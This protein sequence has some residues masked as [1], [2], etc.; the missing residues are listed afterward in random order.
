MRR[1]TMILL[2]NIRLINW[3]GFGNVTMPIGFFTLI[4]GKNGN[5]KSV[6]LDAI[7]YA[8][9]GDTVFNKS[10]DSH[11]TRTLLSYTRGL[12]DATAKTY[13]RPVEKHPNVITHIALEYYDDVETKNFILGTII[14]TNTSDNY[15]SYRYVIDNDALQNIDHLYEEQNVKKPYT[16]SAFQ[17]KY[18][19]KLMNKEQGIAKFMQ[20]TGLKLDSE[21]TRIYLRKLR[22]I[23]SYDPNAKMDQFI[24]DSVLENKKIDFSK[25]IEAREYINKSKS[26]LDMIQNEIDEIDSILADYQG[27][28]GERKRLLVDDI[29][30]VYKQQIDLKQEKESIE[31]KATKA[32]L[33]QTMALKQKVEIEE[34]IDSYQKSLISIEASL[35]NL[36]CVK[37]IQEVKQRLRKL[38]EKQDKL[39][40]EKENLKFFQD[41]IQAIQKL[42]S[43]E[44]IDL[45]EQNILSELCTKTYSV[46]DKKLAVDRLKEAIDEGNKKATEKLVECSNKNQNIEEKISIQKQI[47]NDCEKNHVSFHGIPDYCN[48][49]EEI[50]REFQLRNLNTAAK[51]ACEYVLELK[52]EGWRDAIESFLGP[53]RYTILVEPEYYDIADEVVNRSKYRYAHIFNTK[54]LMKKQIKAQDD[55]V[56]RFL[57]IKNNVAQTYFDYLL[58]RIKA[59]ELDDV[60]NYENAISKEGK[61][62]INMDSYFLQFK[63]LRSYYLGQETLELNRKRA[64]KILE[65]L[66]KERNLCLEE[67]HQEE[68]IRTSL[69]NYRD[70]IKEYNYEA[71][72]Q[73][74]KNSTQIQEDNEILENLLEA[75]KEHQEFMSLTKQQ[76]S[77]ERLLDKENEA[78]KTVDE[79]YHKA[80]A[81]MKNSANQLESI[82]NQYEDVNKKF[83][84]YQLEEYESV[85]KAKKAYD[86]F[87]QNGYKGTGGLLAP[88]SR[89]RAKNGMDKYEKDFLVKQGSYNGKR[90]EENKL[91]TGME[92]HSVYE[93]R[94]NKIWMDDLQ[95]VK[96]EL[97]KQTKQYENNFK[98]EFVLKIWNNC[99]DAKEDLKSI[100]YELNKLQFATKYQ[101]DVHFVKDQSDYAKILTYAEYLNDKKAN[102][103]FSDQISFDQLEK[104]KNEEIIQLEQDIRSIINKIIEKNDVELIEKYADYRNYMTY[105]ILITNDTFE[106]AKL[107]KQTGYNSGA[108]IQI[109]YLLILSSALLMI[110]NG[111]V[112]STRLVFIDE[113]FVKMDPSNIKL[114]L[115]FLKEQKFQVIFCAPDKTEI[116][117][118]EC[119]VILPVLKVKP[120]NMQI[121]IVKFHEDQRY[122]RL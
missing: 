44:N 100:N 6:L 25:L 83:E 118:D 108:E 114:M 99:K 64:E 122:D 115:S 85:Q 63:K 110:Y 107:S 48:L 17:K 12:L 18:G 67:I 61:V 5:G 50:N 56:V 75:Q 78:K 76:K 33:E 116:I 37:P 54:L 11:G 96:Q 51:F 68:Q 88:D 91:P 35:N 89:R 9:Y 8:A 82:E 59:V 62:S 73:Y 74:D 42:L 45:K 47:L 49:K 93:L 103:N 95:S 79:Q 66:N 19:V 21:Q 53:R 41:Q 24:R 57:K 97:D 112:N 55:S 71:F 92:H 26:A 46:V 70:L 30:N 22:G 43:Q 101:F 39:K 15:Q 4:A 32:E 69:L 120:D 29:K 28:E 105:E 31:K 90:S 58:G 113:P 1:S 84:K 34:R 106:K 86:I 20:I 40:Q 98:N 10:S 14:E 72:Q 52:D 60:K 102:G 77:F 16:S 36:D 104:Y 117:G 87:V 27:Y 109:P 119:E 81:I 3:Y 13:M 111:K 65:E 23:M 2:K 38:Q 80:A 121:G 94:R 7:K